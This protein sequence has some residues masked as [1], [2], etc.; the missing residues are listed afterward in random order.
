MGLGKVGVD[1]MDHWR[2]PHG[3]AVFKDLNCGA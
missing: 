2:E 3:D 1:I